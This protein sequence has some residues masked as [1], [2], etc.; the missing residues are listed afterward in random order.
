MKTVAALVKA[1]RASFWMD[2]LA[3]RIPRASRAVRVRG[4]TRS[5]RKG[6]DG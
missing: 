2:V 3:G 4:R 5:Y 6:G 1:R